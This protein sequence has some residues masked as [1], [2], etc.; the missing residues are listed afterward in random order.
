ME[1]YSCLQMKTVVAVLMAACI[2][3]SGFGTLAEISTTAT[4]AGSS[5]KEV[6]GTVLSV[7]SNDIMI[8]ME[9]GNVF[10]FIMDNITDT[11]AQVGDE[12][13]IEYEGDILNY[14]QATS[15]TVTKVYPVT[16]ISGKVLQHDATTIFI[17]ISSTEALGFWLTKDT[18]ITG[19]SDLVMVGDTVTIT[20]LS[21]IHI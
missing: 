12:V 19:L 20:Y 15:I 4:G 18:V 3:L 14:P 7:S 21:L 10:N 13:V 17:E 11:I 1:A 8:K 16:T 9:N 6:A 5:G 2:L